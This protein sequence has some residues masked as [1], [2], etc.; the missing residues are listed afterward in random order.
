MFMPNLEGIHGKY[1]KIPNILKDKKCAAFEKL[2]EDRFQQEAQAYKKQTGGGNF[3]SGLGG[4]P[5]HC[6]RLS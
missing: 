4:F 3:L 5:E 6:P 2:Q 1:S